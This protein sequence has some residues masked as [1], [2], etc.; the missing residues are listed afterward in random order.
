MAVLYSISFLCKSRK[1]IVEAIVLSFWHSENSIIPVVFPYFL[2]GLP[3]KFDV[4][5]LSFLLL[6]ILF[7]YG[8]EKCTPYS[9][10]KNLYI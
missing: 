4:Y 10:L 9:S 1:V 6:E 5:S 2:E 3:R 8:Y 7:S